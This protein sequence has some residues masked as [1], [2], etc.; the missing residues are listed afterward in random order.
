MFH[1]HKWETA[2]VTYVPA[3]LVGMEK[4]RNIA[5]DQLQ[6]M[7]TPHTYVTLRCTECG[8]LKER[9]FR[10]KPQQIISTQSNP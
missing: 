1:R 2:N 3:V 10:G 8:D 7:L 6:H 4:A 5:T 9:E